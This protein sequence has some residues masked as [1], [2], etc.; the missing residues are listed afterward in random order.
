MNAK[1]LREKG[2]SL[3]E[4]GRRLGCSHTTVSSMLSPDHREKRRKAEQNRRDNVPEYKEKFNAQRR[5]KWSSDSDWRQKTQDANQ[6][7]D[8]HIRRP[9]EKHQLITYFVSCPSLNKVKIGKTSCIRSRLNSL[10]CGNPEEITFLGI[11]DYNEAE[12]HVRFAD[13]HVVREWFHLSDR[14]QHFIETECRDKP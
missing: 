13:E 3:R 4:I 6:K 9:K 11:C 5:N 2:L 1:E 14:I 10:Q 7:Y 8:Q 12:L